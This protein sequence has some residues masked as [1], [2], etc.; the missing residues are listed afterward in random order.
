M[1]IVCVEEDA[2]DA[3]A[4]LVNARGGSREL[5]SPKRAS[6]PNRRMGA[7]A[8]SHADRILIVTS[9]RGKVVA[10]IGGLMSPND[11]IMSRM[12]AFKESRAYA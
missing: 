8:E 2:K 1:D 5:C 6:L 10:V 12:L 11:V 7:G 9:R 3:L 4:D